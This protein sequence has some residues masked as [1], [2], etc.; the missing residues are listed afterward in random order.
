MDTQRAIEKLLQNFTK[1]LMKVFS[2]SVVRAVGQV[3]GPSRASLPAASTAT[4]RTPGRKPAA[5]AAPAPKGKPGRPPKN[6]PKPAARKGKVDKSSPAEVDDLSNQIIAALKRSDRNLAAREIMDKLELRPLDAGRFN[7][8]LGKLKD[9]GR[10][11]Q[12][13]DR[14]MARYGIGGGTKA[15]PGKP[16]R[17]PK[18][19]A[20]E[21]A[22]ESEAPAEAPADES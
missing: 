8:A 1:E 7:Y 10:V 13:G 18:A 6:Q 11:A 21:T 2:E 3:A 17:K 19:P 9:D 16:G 22:S 14:R 4:R 15:K 12:H 20:V 5:A